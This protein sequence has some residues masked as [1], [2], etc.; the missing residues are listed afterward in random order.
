MTK[1]SLNF[2]RKLVGNKG[3]P[4]VSNL[5][6]LTVREPEID[7][8]DGTCGLSWTIGVLVSSC[9]GFL[10]EAVRT[11]DDLVEVGKDVLNREEIP[12][13]N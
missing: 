7:N 2:L 13:S 12:I 3:V 4:P 5:G 11:G 8:V 9:G 1:L 10:A 6:L